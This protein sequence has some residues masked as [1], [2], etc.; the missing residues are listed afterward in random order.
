MLANDHMPGLTDQICLGASNR[1]GNR[2]VD[3]MLTN[4]RRHLLSHL[5]LIQMLP[6]RAVSKM[7]SL[8]PNLRNS[9]VEYLRCCK[10]NDRM[11]CLRCTPVQQVFGGFAY[12]VYLRVCGDRCCSQ[13]P[14]PSWEID[15]TIL[16]DGSPQSDLSRPDKICDVMLRIVL[17]DRR[18]EDL[19][20]LVVIQ[21]L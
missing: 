4:Q 18:Q 6:S 20:G 10:N 5:V 8:S 2:C 17:F 3:S 12:F 9:R 15:N 21:I 19:S 16:A 11:A 13:S 14:R 7:R 1:S